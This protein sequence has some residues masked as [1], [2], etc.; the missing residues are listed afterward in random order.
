VLLDF[1]LALQFLS[2]VPEFLQ[3]SFFL[4]AFEVGLTLCFLGHVQLMFE[5]ALHLLSCLTLTLKCAIFFLQLRHL[6]P[7]FLASSLRAVMQQFGFCY[8]GGEFVQNFL[9]LH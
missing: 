8:L 1:L 2:V 7:Q 5:A 4:L 9:I 6:S 3:L